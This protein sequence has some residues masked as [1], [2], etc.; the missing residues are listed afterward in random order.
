M[1]FLLKAIKAQK[2]ADGLPELE[3]KYSTH[4]HTGK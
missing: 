4:F 1:A 3:R 2:E